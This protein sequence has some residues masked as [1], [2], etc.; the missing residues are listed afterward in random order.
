MRN[1]SGI[2]GPPRDIKNC[3]AKFSTTQILILVLIIVLI[4]V[5]VSVGVN[6]ALNKSYSKPAP[7][8]EKKKLIFFANEYEDDT[9]KFHLSSGS[10][11]FND[12]DLGNDFIFQFRTWVVVIWLL[13]GSNGVP[14]IWLRT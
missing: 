12:D 4:A 8:P 9:S 2:G 11:S 3:F 7:G 13:I 6:V 10:F 5:A 1:I 14:S